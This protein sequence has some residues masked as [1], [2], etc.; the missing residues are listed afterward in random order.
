MVLSVADNDLIP[1]LL[2]EP[3]FQKDDFLLL[4][5]KQR[6]VV[7]YE[8]GDW[9]IVVYLVGYDCGNAQHP[10]HAS[11]VERNSASCEALAEKTQGEID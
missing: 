1:N 7:L 4:E 2:K 6:A 11:L 8:T 5:A 3:T 9:L 10:A